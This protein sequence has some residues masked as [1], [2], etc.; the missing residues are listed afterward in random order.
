MFHYFEEFVSEYENRFEREYGYFRPVVKEAADYFSVHS[1][2][3]YHLISLGDSPFKRRKGI[4]Y[5]ARK[6]VLDAWWE[7]TAASPPPIADILPKFDISL[8]GYDKMLLKRRTE[9]NGITRWSYPIGSVL[10]RKTKRKEERY[11]IQY[12][13]DGYRVRK[14]LKGVKTR[15]E[16]VK[17]LNFEVADAQR[18]QYNFQK[19]KIT[20][21][22]MAD[23]YLEKYAKVKKK[24]WRRSDW[25]FL[26]RLKPYF[27]IYK[28]TKISPLMIEEYIA[29]RKE[30]GLKNSSVNRELSCLR[31]IFN[32]AIDWDYV[33]VNPVRKVKSLSEKGS[34]RERVLSEDEEVRLF[35]AAALHLKPMLMVAIY[36]GFRRG[37]IFNLK[38]QNVDFE[39]GEIRTSQSKT[40]VGR[41]V[42]MNSEVMTMLYSM[43]AQNGNCEHVFVNPDTGKPYTD[44][45]RAF[46][47][48][49]K[50][51]G[52]KNLKFHDLRHTFGSRL[53][54]NGAN[55]NLVREL[56]GHA[57][58]V[59]T[60]RYLHSQAD[61]KK[62]AIESLITKHPKMWQ[63]NDKFSESDAL[64]NLISSS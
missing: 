38:W 18:G 12:Q 9:L 47:G 36:T 55:L 14:A 59:T 64:T 30:E 21:S 51:T 27:G 43:K 42:P 28:L 54:R 58:I 52:I 22:E 2:S 41:A 35:E 6:S 10:M 29:G 7:E 1:S 45:S 61:E 46:N 50:R 3:I 23:L 26:R 32:L 44:I 17:V 63:M 62:Q 34:M 25:V 60:Q 5:R 56:M 20:F 4:G 33:A 49:C 53:V 15:A 40:G 24:G 39:K 13:V 37:A 57:S 11:Y 19:K 16:A 48:A 31:K 8:N